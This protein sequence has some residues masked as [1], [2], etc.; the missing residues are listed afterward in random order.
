[1]PEVLSHARRQF[2]RV[3]PAVLLAV[4]M[5]GCVSDEAL[6]QAAKDV[7]EAFRVEYERILRERGTRV[8]PRR[9]DDAVYRLRTAAMNLH[10][11]VES[12][13]L[14][15]GYVRFSAPAPQPLTLREWGE[16][17]DADLPKMRAIVEKHV[18]PL[19]K[20]AVPFEPAG[21]DIV[22]NATVVPVPRGSEISL[23]MRMREVK[24]PP[25][26]YPR[27]EYPPPTSVQKGLDKIWG[28]ID[29]AMEVKPLS[30]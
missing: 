20:W 2:A 7:S 4:L 10:M 30:R 13:D 15:L 6:I 5:A 29:V 23:S 9:G 12:Y 3:V 26:G 19:L 27:R 18:G 28:A 21:L 17:A 22:I 25:T 14:D 8:Y 16:A 11:R 24:P 1:M